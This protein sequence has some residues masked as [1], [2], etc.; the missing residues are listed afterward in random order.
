TNERPFFFFDKHQAS[1]KTPV[2]LKYP[3]AGIETLYPGAIEFGR[4]V[5]A[6]TGDR[7]R[8]LIDLFVSALEYLLTEDYF[9]N[10]PVPII[11][12]AANPNNASIFEKIGLRRDNRVMLPAGRSLSASYSNQLYDLYFG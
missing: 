12:E 6:Q 3:D 10:N 2:A 9:R 5:P 11:A 8:S 1:P 4:A 7:T